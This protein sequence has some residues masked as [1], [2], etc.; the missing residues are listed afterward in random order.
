[1]TMAKLIDL[2]PELRL[3]ITDHLHRPSD[4]ARLCVTCKR[5]RDAAVPRLYESV[6]LNLD[7]STF[8]AL[9]GYFRAGNPGPKHVRSLCF[10]PHAPKDRE[11]AV[12]V[13]RLALQLVPRNALRNIW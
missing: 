1:M 5:L 4:L 8:R 9:N 6:E 3:A 7:K 12:K 13:M 10:L 2:P 11:D